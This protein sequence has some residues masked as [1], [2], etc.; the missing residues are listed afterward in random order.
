MACAQQ[1]NSGRSLIL[2][3]ITSMNALI[4]AIDGPAGAGKSTVSKLLASKINANLL[5]T[6]AFYRTITLALLQRNL[7]SQNIDAKSLS[8]LDIVQEVVNGVVTMY[9]NGNDVSSEIRQDT[10]SKKVSEFATLEIVRAYAVKLQQQYIQD[11]LSN[12]ISVVIEGRDIATVVAPEANLKIFLTASPEIRAKRRS[13]E[14]ATDEHETLENLQERDRVDSSRDISPLRKSSDA[15]E[16]DATDKSAEE[17]ADIIYSHI[18][19]GA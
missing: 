6:G 5:D 15:I 18:V 9:L 13:L 12:N 17:V 10:I 8:E 14:L 11:C 3:T 19:V 7:D 1:S 4:I 16:I 2:A